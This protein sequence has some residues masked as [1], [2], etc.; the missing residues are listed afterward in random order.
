MSN[1]SRVQAVFDGLAGRAVPPAMALTF[2]DAVINQRSLDPDPENP[3]GPEARCGLFI[4]WAV[5]VLKKHKA[6]E[7]S[8]ATY[9]AAEQIRQDAM[10]SAAADL[11]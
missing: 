3:L 9:L 2:V 11:E 4:R 8:Q 1:I 5:N 7:A 6:D 10:I